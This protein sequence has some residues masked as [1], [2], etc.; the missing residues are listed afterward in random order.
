MKRLPRKGSRGY[1][2]KDQ[3]V[4]KEMIRIGMLTAEQCS[5][6]KQLHSLFSLQDLAESL[7][8]N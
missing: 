7:Q 4:T 8:Q 1:Q 6:V 2:G 5:A 3:E